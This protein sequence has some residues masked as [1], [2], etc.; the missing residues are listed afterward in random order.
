MA[1]P[2][3]RCRLKVDGTAD[4]S[5]LCFVEDIG[6]GEAA[7]ASDFLQVVRFLQSVADGST[8]FVGSCLIISLLAARNSGKDFAAGRA[9]KSVVDLVA[10]NGKLV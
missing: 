4:Q 7:F 9:A 10:G 2:N 5:H 6:R 8:A 3:L 1:L